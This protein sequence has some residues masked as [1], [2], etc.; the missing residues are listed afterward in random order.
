M[1]H[2]VRQSCVAAF[3]TGKM[4]VNYWRMTHGR[5]LYLSFKACFLNIVDG[6]SISFIGPSETVRDKSQ[7]PFSVY[8]CCFSHLHQKRL[9]LCSAAQHFLS[10]SHKCTFTE[11]NT[12]KFLLSLP[13]V[14]K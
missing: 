2:K 5:I 12:L 3:K 14:I 10:G 8:T 9:L 11:Q 13:P 1:G 4:S 7:P 6:I